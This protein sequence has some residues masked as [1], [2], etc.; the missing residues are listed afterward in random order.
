MVE[1]LLLTASLPKTHTYCMLHILKHKH[2]PLLLCSK[3]TSHILGL[4]APWGSILPVL[5]LKIPYLNSVSYLSF[6]LSYGKGKLWAYYFTGWSELYVSISYEPKVM[7]CDSVSNTSK[8]II[9]LP[10]TIFWKQNLKTQIKPELSVKV[11]NRRA[12]FT[13]N[14]EAIFIHSHGTGN[15]HCI[16]YH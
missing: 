12:G 6:V 8:Q 15:P 13:V 9:I 2:T 10:L 16:C 4:L 5:S 1:L 14:R 3:L 7:A 11:Y